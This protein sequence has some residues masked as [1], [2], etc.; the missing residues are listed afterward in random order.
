[1]SEI[2]LYVGNADNFNVLKTTENIVASIR[3]TIPV[4]IITT[5]P[6]SFDHLESDGV[7]IFSSSPGARFPQFGVLKQYLATQNPAAV[8]NITRPVKHG[9][10]VTAL[11]R[12][13]GVNSVY[14]YSGDRFYDYKVRTGVDRAV[15]YGLNNIFNRLP[16]ALADEYLALE[17]VGK[18]RLITRGVSPENISILRPPID[19]DR[20][21]S[22]TP[23]IELDIPENRNVF[24]FV[25]RLSRLK[26]IHTLE[27]A[28]ETV[29]QRRTDVHFVLVGG[30]EYNITVAPNHVTTVGRVPPEQV[31]SYY[32]AADVL[33]HPSLTETIGRVIMEAQAAGIPVVA[34][35]A[36]GM[37]SVTDNTF[38]E[39]DE[40]CEMLIDFESLE[41]EDGRLHSIEHLSGDYEAFFRRFM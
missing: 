27:R 6:E 39:E 32:A 20:F 33:V 13:H 29:M 25:G 4:D 21:A 9:A 41:V 11:C 23:E 35:D 31:P 37:G 8:M 5:V 34:R 3:S 12:K 38:N 18:Q 19:Y 2:G 7:R 1:M 40:L 24:L 16:V 10:L 17:P 30:G 15:S 22:A 36:G 28:I 14:R 26:G